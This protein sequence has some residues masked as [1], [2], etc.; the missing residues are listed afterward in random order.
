MAISFLPYGCTQNSQKSYK[1]KNVL[2]EIVE[3]AY[4]DEGWKVCGNILV[5]DDVNYLY[6]SHNLWQNSQPLTKTCEGKIPI[7]IY[8]KLKQ[9]ILNKKWSISKGKHPT[10]EL[11]IDDTKTIHPD[12]IVELLD[13]LQ[14]EVLKK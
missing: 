3:K 9:S 12:G 10:Y 5:F 4:H 13:Y 7:K 11:G 2:C 6:K 14:A 1:N 8:A